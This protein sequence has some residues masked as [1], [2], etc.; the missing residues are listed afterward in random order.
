ML[1]RRDLLIRAGMAGAAAFA[2]PITT[3]FATAAQPSTPVNFNVPAGACDCH[4]HIFG[5]PRR[6]PFAASRSY[7]PES[8]SV[9]EMRSLHRALHTERV[10][11]L[12]RSFRL[13]MAATSI[14][15]PSGLRAPL[16]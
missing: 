3:A 13:M 6:F 5:D 15:S 14:D 10:V 7:T 9:A 2:R 16:N 8:A 12:S 4:T 11:K 1:S